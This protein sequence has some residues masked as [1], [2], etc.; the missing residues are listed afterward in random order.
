MTSAASRR[1][2]A[3]L[4]HLSF[5]AVGRASDLPLHQVAVN[6]TKS[7]RGQLKVTSP[8]DQVSKDLEGADDQRDD[9]EAGWPHLILKS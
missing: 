7:C 2:A 1:G 3:P 8:S 9:S 6:F 5:K 4:Q